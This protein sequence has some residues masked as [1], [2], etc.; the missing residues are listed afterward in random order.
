MNAKEYKTLEKAKAILAFEAQ[1]G[2]YFE[3]QWVALAEAENALIV[4]MR[5]ADG[6]LSMT[7][8][9]PEHCE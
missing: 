5:V 6:E 1:R 7:A 4:A 3:D 8:I 2:C 9:L